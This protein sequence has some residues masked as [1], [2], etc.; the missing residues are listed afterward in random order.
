MK[1]VFALF[2]AV[3]G[4]TGCDPT[5]LGSWW[6]ARQLEARPAEFAVQI[7]RGVAMK[8]SDGTEL[9]ADIY[10]PSGTGPQPTILVRIPYSKT[11]LNKTI[12]TVVGRYWAERG[13]HV[14]IQGTRGRYESGGTYDPFKHERQDG[15]ETLRW[16]AEQPWFDGQLGMWGGSYFGYTQWVLADRT[17]PGP[18]AL[19]IQIASS[20]FYRMFYY[21]GAF[22]LESA[23]NWA[24]SSYGKE[25]IEPDEGALDRGFH[26][27]PLIEADDRAAVDIQFFND[28]VNHPTRDDYWRAVDGE[29]RA[30]TLQAPVLLMAGWYDPFL[31]GQLADFIRIRRESRREVAAASRLI[32][33]PWA[34][35]RA[36]MLPDGTVAPN[37]RLESFAPSVPWFDQHLRGAAEAFPAPVRIYAMGE[38]RWRDEQE[39][40][41]ARTRYTEFFLASGGRANSSAGDGRLSLTPAPEDNPADTFI[42]DPLRPVP[43]AGGAMIGPRAGIALQNKIEERSD[44]L[45]YTTPPLDVDLEVTGPV[46]LVLH[47][48]TT[49]VSTDFTAKLV[50]VFP[51]GSAFNMTE[52]ILRRSYDANV[53]TEITLELWPTSTLFRRGHRIRLEVSSSNFPRFDRNPNTGKPIATEKETRTAHQTIYHRGDMPSRLILPII[54]KISDIAPTTGKIEST[55]GP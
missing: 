23:L 36:V 6:L 38:N 24:V 12:A 9:V 55:I 14:V 5:Q 34:H 53:P 41:L 52:G 7:D 19:N 42:Y 13:Y 39:W 54:P 51:D 8:A 10:H 45:V 20:E 31:P 22:S 2:L 43:S 18:S 28:W 50:N 49:A 30:T 32:V 15:I 40:P 4:L 47:V 48:S 11:F 21:G 46:N 27:F 1:P 44:V 35:A 37:Y 29:N 25:D 16:M 3:S 17:M 33:G 26:G